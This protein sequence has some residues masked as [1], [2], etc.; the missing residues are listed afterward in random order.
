MCSVPDGDCLGLADPSEY[1][2]SDAVATVEPDKK[3]Y[4]SAETRNS[5]LK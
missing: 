4:A 5:C 1:S 2:R 3:D